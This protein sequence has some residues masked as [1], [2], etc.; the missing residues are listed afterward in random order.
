MSNPGN[1]Y[2]IGIA[3]SPIYNND[4]ISNGLA[5]RDEENLKS[6]A[7]EILPYALSQITDILGDVFVGLTQ[8][9]GMLATA[10]QDPNVNPH[11][12]QELQELIDDVNQRITINIPE[13]LEL[14]K[15]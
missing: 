10:E 9:K 4:N 11:K 13:Y 8:I 6:R 1:P 2:S 5:I 14:L 3:Q 7:P 15:V 12:L